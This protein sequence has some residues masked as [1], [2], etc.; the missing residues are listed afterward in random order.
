MEALGPWTFERV[1]CVN[2]RLGTPMRAPYAF[3]QMVFLGK[4]KQLS[5]SG[6]RSEESRAKDD[7]WAYLL[8]QESYSLYFYDLFEICNVKK[9]NG[10]VSMEGPPPAHTCFFWVCLKGLVNG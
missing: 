1:T 10:G 8:P 5:A 4:Q 6:S 7:S 9:I 2:Q 3:A